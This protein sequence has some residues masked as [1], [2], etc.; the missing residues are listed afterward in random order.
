MELTL[1]TGLVGAKNIIKMLLDCLP[2]AFLVYTCGV[3]HS[4]GGNEAFSSPG[5]GLDIEEFGV[6]IPFSKE[7][8]SRS[9]PTSASLHGS[10]AETLDLHGFFLNLC[11]SRVSFR[12]SIA[13]SN[14]KMISFTMAE[15]SL[16]LLISLEF[17]FFRQFVVKRSFL[18]RLM[19]GLPSKGA[20]C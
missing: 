2:F 13:T 19:K 8:K 5:R 11:S 4:G 9:L 16:L 1:I 14:L 3:T 10:Q 17:H 7:N 20:Y 18:C 6:T 15:Q 12:F